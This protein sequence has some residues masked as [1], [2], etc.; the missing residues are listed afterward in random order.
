[1]LHGDFIHDVHRFHQKY[2]PVVRIAPNELSFTTEQAQRDIYAR[3]VADG[4]PMP[5]H[6]SFSPPAP[7]GANPVSSAPKEDHIRQR[8][9]LAHGFSEKA[10]SE[11]EP[12]IRTYVDLLMDKLKDTTNNETGVSTLDI[13]KY[14]NWTVFDIF[15]D[16][17]FGESF[18][19]LVGDRYHEWTSLLKFFP[20]AALMGNSLSGYGILSPLLMLL[21]IPKQVISGA[22]DHWNLCVQKVRQRIER[23]TNRKDIMSYI[24]SHDDSKTTTA[25][26]VP[27][28]E[29]TGYIL[30]FAGA[31]TTASSLSATV[32]YLIRY[33]AKFAKLREEIRLQFSNPE[34]ITFRSSTATRLP[35]MHAVLQESLRLAPPVAGHSPRV[36]PSG[37]GVVDGNVFPEGVSNVL[38]IA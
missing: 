4:Y 28:L 17:G 38:Y 37:G 34:E 8:R 20:K 32:S 15:G 19:C 1:V 5:K 27:E 22:K 29:A 31:E 7:N 14:F 35:Y 23:Q 9:A 11:Q 3:R 21:F 10:L 30:I 24:L 36:V 26:T 12:L 6:P 33:P 2:G 13:G 18:D 25:L 16:L